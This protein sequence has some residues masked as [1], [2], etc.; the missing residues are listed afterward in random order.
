MNFKVYQGPLAPDIVLFLNPHRLNISENHCDHIYLTRYTLG[1]G[2][3][4]NR[5]HILNNI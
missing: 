1:R 3:V 4:A 2:E 5:K